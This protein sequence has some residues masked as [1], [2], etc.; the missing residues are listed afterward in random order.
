[1][2]SKVLQKLSYGL[3]V[4]TANDGTKDNGCIINTATQLA[5]DPLNVSIAVN[6]AN[7]TCQMIESTR[8]F[9]ISVLSE[10]ARFDTF[11]R[12]GFQSG[13]DTDKFAGFSHCKRTTN[14][15]LAITEGTNAYIS[16]YVMQQVDLGSH[17]L[18]I[19]YPT[20]GEILNQVP[21]ATYAY[22][23]AN[24]KPK[25][26]PVGKTSEGE[27]IWRCRICGY[28]YV[29]EEL[30]EDFICPLCKHPASDFEKIVRGA[31]EA[32]SK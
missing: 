11:K 15:T 31:S 22:Y 16:V 10:D 18:F 24:I 25:P 1:M 29:G 3:F 17:M 20:D 2:N 23:F 27:T 30:P 26:Q 13:R 28:E 19:G 21:S 8:K 9:T 5:S 12:F 6:K 14:G 32:Q 4:L 7:Y